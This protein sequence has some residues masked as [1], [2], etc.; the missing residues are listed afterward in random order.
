MKL[1][2][3]NI[4]LIL[5][6]SLNII[7]NGV[8]EKDGQKYLDRHN[9]TILNDK[10][11]SYKL[12]EAKHSYVL[13]IDNTSD[14]MRYLHLFDEVTIKVMDELPEM[15]FYVI[16]IATF[17]KALDYLQ[18]DPKDIPLYEFYS[19]GNKIP[20]TDFFWNRFRMADYLRIRYS[21]STRQLK[22]IKEVQDFILKEETMLYLHDGSI[23][24]FENKNLKDIESIAS[25]YTKLEVAWVND[26]KL[27][28]EACKLSDLGDNLDFSNKQHILVYHSSHRGIKTKIYS[29]EKFDFT[30]M[31]KF[32]NNNRFNYVIDYDESVS[33]MLYT[34]TLPAIFLV[35][36]EIPEHKRKR[37]DFDWS[38]KLILRI[39]T[40]S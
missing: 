24:S 17:P 5:I 15:K 1:R 29:D 32:Y 8:V 2:L 28:K 27:F 33:S 26:K 19:Y 39:I 4:F 34:E 14:S 16:N 30:K 23:L 12:N 25:L 22:S 6:C 11:I 38:K 10:V 9:Y 18:V 21:G 20:Y 3:T 31:R 7:Q 35:V 40:K 37:K 36:T 13:I